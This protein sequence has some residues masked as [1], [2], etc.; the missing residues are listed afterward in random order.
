MKQIILII[1][2]AC[3]SINAFAGN[4]LKSNVKITK[5]DAVTYGGDIK[6]Q[7]TPRHDIGGLMCTSDF[8]LILKANSNNY[9]ALFSLALSAKFNDATVSIGADDTNLTGVFCE[10]SRLVVN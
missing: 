2:T 5:I 6:I 7:T 3:F 4:T 9:E 10:F 8:W 1:V